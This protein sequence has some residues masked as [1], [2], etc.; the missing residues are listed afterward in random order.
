MMG[1]SAW[2]AASFFVASSAAAAGLKPSERPSL[3]G[4]IETML[5]LFP[6]PMQ[7]ELRLAA[8]VIAWLSL[9][10]EKLGDETRDVTIRFTGWYGVDLGETWLDDRR[11]GEVAIGFARIRAPQIGFEATFGRQF[12]MLGLARAERMDGLHIAQDLPGGL[13]LEVFGGGAPGPRITYDRGDFLWGARLSHRWRDLI[14]GGVSFLQARRDVE[15]A[16]ELVGA[17]LVVNPKAWLEC[18]AGAL[19]DTVGETLAQLDLFATFYPGSGLRV[20]TDWRRV[21][22]VALLDKTSIFSVFSDAVRDEMGADVSWRVHGRV[23][24]TADAHLLA[25]EDNDPGYRLSLGATARLGS[26]NQTTVTTRLGRWRDSAGGYFEW[27]GAAR[28][29]FTPA[30][31]A[32]GDVQTYVYDNAVSGNSISFGVTAALGYELARRLRVLLSA[33]GGVTPMFERRGQIMA[34]LEYDFVRFYK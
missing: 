31:F 8:P 6:D 11:A 33:E 18:G 24:L 25:F 32:A 10:A 17:D 7:R 21:V 28:H 14:T 2:F 20:A 19:F 27:R 34:K 15:I 9:D 13:R 1:R 12:L 5:N 26:W 3:A 4:S 22:P 30:L 29:R 23:T 16:R